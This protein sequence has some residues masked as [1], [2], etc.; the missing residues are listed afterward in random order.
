MWN[1]ENATSVTI[2]DNVSYSKNSGPVG[3]I[4]VTPTMPTTTYTITA[5]GQQGKNATSTLTVLTKILQPSLSATYQGGINTVVVKDNQLLNT[6]KISWNA[7]NLGMNDKLYIND[8]LY[9]TSGDKEVPERSSSYKPSYEYKF[10][11]KDSVTNQIKVEKSMPIIVK[12]DNSPL[13]AIITG[14][15]EISGNTQI[16][17]GNPIILRWTTDKT[18]VVDLEVDGV[19][20]QHAA[21]NPSGINV[22]VMDKD[23]KTFTLTAWNDANRNSTKDVKS[24]TL[25]ASK[26]LAPQIVTFVASNKTFNNS[27]DKVSVTLNWKVINETDDIR[28]KYAENLQGLQVA[29]EG[30]TTLEVRNNSVIKIEA[31]KSGKTTATQQISIDEPLPP[32]PHIVFFNVSGH[33]TEDPVKI[34]KSS[35]IE[36]DFDVTNSKRILLSFERNTY[37]VTG[38]DH[39]T[40]SSNGIGG[41]A[42]LDAYEDYDKIKRHDSKTLTIEITADD[43]KDPVIS[44]FDVV[45]KAGRTDHDVDVLLT[46]NVSDFNSSTDTLRISYTLSTGNNNLTVN[47]LPSGTTYP[48]VVKNNSDIKLSLYRGDVLKQEKS[49]TVSVVYSEPIINVF[50]FSGKDGNDVIFEYSEPIYVDYSVSNA[51]RV[52]I[53][54]D[55]NTYSDNKI[56][57]NKIKIDSTSISAGQKHVLDIIAYEF[58]GNNPSGRS[59]TSRLTFSNRPIIILDPKIILS[60][61]VQPTYRNNLANAET[62]Q[63]YSV[64]KWNISNLQSTDSIYVSYMKDNKDVNEPVQNAAEGT[65]SIVSNNNNVITLN[66]YGNS[67]DGKIL[68]K[69]S[70]SLPVN[71]TDKPETDAPVITS[72]NINGHSNDFS[73]IENANGLVTYTTKNAKS[74]ILNN[75]GYNMGLEPGS[76]PSS[77]RRNFTINSASSGSNT[78]Q[79]IAY[80]NENRIGRSDTKTIVITPYAEKSPVITSFTNNSSTLSEDSN[81]NVS[82]IIFSWNVDNF[83]TST[84]EIYIEQSPPN[85]NTK[86]NIFHSNSASGTTN[87]ISM[88]NGSAVKLIVKRN[89]VDVTYSDNGS[90]ISAR[91]RIPSYPDVEGTITINSSEYIDANTVKISYT[92]NA[93]YAKRLRIVTSNNPNGD[94]ITGAEDKIQSFNGT[95]SGVM[96]Q[97]NSQIILYG[98][99]GNN[100]EKQLMTRLISVDP[101]YN[102]PTVYGFSMS[103]EYDPIDSNEQMKMGYIK[104]SADNFKYVK[105]VKINYI[106][107]NGSQKSDFWVTPSNKN[108][109][110]FEKD[111]I[112]LL[113]S[114][115]TLEATDMLGKTVTLLSKNVSFDVPQPLIPSVKY[116]TADT[117]HPKVGEYVTLRWQ[118]ENVDSVLFD[119]NGKQILE[120]PSGN[121][122]IQINSTMVFK[123]IP[124]VSGS[125]NTE[126]MASLTIEPVDKITPT[127]N[128]FKE[129]TGASTFYTGDTITLRWSTTDAFQLKLTSDDQTFLGATFGGSMA[130]NAGTNVTLPNKSEVSYT[131]TATSKDG[132]SVYKVISFN[133]VDKTRPPV[134]VETPMIDSFTGPSSV[135][136]GAPATFSWSAKNAATVE[137]WTK[138]GKS[139]IRN[140]DAYKSVSDSASLTW[141]IN[142]SITENI[143]ENDDVVYL[144][145]T[146]RTKQQVSSSINIKV[147]AASLLTPSILDFSGPTTAMAGIANTY[148]W[149]VTNTST[150]TL[151]TPGGPV[152]TKTYNTNSTVSDSS[153]YTFSQTVAFTTQ[154]LTLKATSPD[155]ISLEKTILVSVNPSY[156]GGTGI[157]VGGACPDPMMSVLMF[158][159]TY[160]LA[161]DLRPGDEI[162]TM[163]EST[164][165]YGIYKIKYAFLTQQPKLKFTFEDNTYAIVST[166]HGFLLIGDKW[167]GASNIMI[168]DTIQCLSGNNKTITTIEDMGIGNVIMIEV[169][170]AHTYILEDLIS[171]NMQK[172]ASSEV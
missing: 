123:L 50:K 106:S 159:K 150:V 166:S 4:T 80:E 170:D 21:Q 61:D 7:I 114:T 31:V 29:A 20:T 120:S 146:S 140:Y 70:E 54:L 155:G 107:L 3:E 75:N 15:S 144:T 92:Y 110:H 139:I 143:T 37:D 79:I 85:S 111:I 116:F 42:Q 30:T 130:A 39:L 154:M 59:A 94:I 87:G 163:N 145:V 78:I 135:I 49:V 2:V 16:L 162:Y 24:I 77:G 136:V 53:K 86:S 55:G 133:L 6:T 89:S 76:T 12:F 27:Y 103:G 46:W 65:K 137:I 81:K 129:S 44:L 90:P 51:A 19:I 1:T 69:A 11:I 68:K 98:T 73:S 14:F 169:E 97:N 99:D 164:G 128:D 102:V 57:S 119:N 101:P 26:K 167:A 151:S 82:G 5:F 66:L 25:I 17:E 23:S 63:V 34:H 36:F 168:G 9:P 109:P 165:E 93:I 35:T 125:A 91:V 40:L 158:D 45:K 72:F 33:T 71:A 121:R 95:K 108:L 118:T 64:I 156:V 113:N 60:Y 10:V 117:L 18:A 161:K 153:V 100:N 141:N 47:P 22:G 28:I 157:N 13:Q 132:V 43:P 74:V 126:L 149:T 104:L 122:T 56:L 160:K 115:L 152:I 134:V 48:L 131:L 41:V 171:H 138:S 124:M 62:N 88:I 67:T 38:K 52:I 58:E 148:N 96:V 32:G 84:D 83:N 112:A 172:K 105:D 147:K 127:I 142:E 8:Q